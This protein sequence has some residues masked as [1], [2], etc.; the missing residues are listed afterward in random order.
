MNE[1]TT[2]YTEFVMGRPIVVDIPTE[3]M[4]GRETWGVSSHLDTFGP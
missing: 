2:F 1:K 3:T 4:I